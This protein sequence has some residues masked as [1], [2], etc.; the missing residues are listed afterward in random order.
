MNIVRLI[1]TSQLDPNGHLGMHEFCSFKEDSEL[2]KKK[3]LM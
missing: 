2:C 1:H 3:K